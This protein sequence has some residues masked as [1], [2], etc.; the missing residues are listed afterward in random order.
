MI[1][2]SSNHWRCTAPGSNTCDNSNLALEASQIS[3][4]DKKVCHGEEDFMESS[5]SGELI[6]WFRD[7]KIS[8]E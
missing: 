1:N 4:V 2:N 7:K 8:S 5:R 3:I 6:T